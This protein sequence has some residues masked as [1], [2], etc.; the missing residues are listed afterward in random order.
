MFFYPIPEV[1]HVITSDM[2]ACRS[3]HTV[4]VPTSFGSSDC[5]VKLDQIYTRLS[6]VEKEPIPTGTLQSKLTD[7]GE[8]FTADENGVQIQS[9]SNPLFKHVTPRSTKVLGSTC[10]CVQIKINV[11]VY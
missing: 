1:S 3:K 9:K 8:L 4:K 11:K 5:Q 10:T 6:W 2:G 7:Y